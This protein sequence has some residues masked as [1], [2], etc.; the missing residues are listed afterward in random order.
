MAKIGS[1]I[2]ALLIQGVII[3]AILYILNTILNLNVLNLTLTN[4]LPFY[5]L[6]ILTFFIAGIVKAIMDEYI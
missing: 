5:G 4:I 6:I 2:I 3:T 1:A